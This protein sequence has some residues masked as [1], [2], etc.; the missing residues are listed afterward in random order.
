VATTVEIVV[1]QFEATNARDFKAA[2]GAYAEDVTLVV[3]GVVSGEETAT[4]RAA[5]GEWFGD[6]FRQFGPDYGFEIE[7]SR[8]SGDQVFVVAAHHG[9]GRASG[10]PVAGRSAYVYTVRDGKITRVEMWFDREAA[11]AD[12]RD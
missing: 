2:M 10:A 3:H 12:F 8:G 6:W 9:R 7:E 4:G 11:L 5:V 1:G